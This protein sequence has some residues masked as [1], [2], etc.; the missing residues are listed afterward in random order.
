ML[1]IWGSVQMGLGCR[2]HRSFTGQQ[3]WKVSRTLWGFGSAGTK[4]S[5][6]HGD[7]HRTEPRQG[8]VQLSK[9]SGSCPGWSGGA[10]SDTSVYKQLGGCQEPGPKRIDS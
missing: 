7:L 10:D 8:H 6:P 3:L 9:L 4:G 2:G 1:R 5:Q